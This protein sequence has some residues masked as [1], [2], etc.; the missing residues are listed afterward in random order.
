MLLLVAA[1]IFVTLMIWTR[2]HP[3]RPDDPVAAAMQDLSDKL[4]L[5]VSPPTGGGGVKVTAVRPDS[6]GARLG[7]R[8]GDRIVAVGDRSIWHPPGLV[9]AIAKVL[10]SGYPVSV[11]VDTN[12]DYHSIIIGRGQRAGASGRGRAAGR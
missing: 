9:D 4:G 10:S 3:Q 2:A 8:A 12:G 1:I 7:F 5:E 11:M 6:P